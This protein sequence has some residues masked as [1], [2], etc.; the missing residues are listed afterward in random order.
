M[1]KT[2]LVPQVDRA[3]CR[4]CGSCVKACPCQAIEL[5]ERGPIFHCAGKCHSEVVCP[6]GSDCFCICEEVCPN[7]AI[8][9]PFEIVLEA[10]QGEVPPS[11]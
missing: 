3:R 4:L 7:D 9:C 1:D 10:D 6:V 2:S 8:E 11:P 5:G